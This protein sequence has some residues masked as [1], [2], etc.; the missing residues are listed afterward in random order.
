MFLCERVGILIIRQLIAGNLLQQKQVIRL[1]RVQS[2]DDIIAIT[3]RP[4]PQSVS[5]LYSFRV[6][7]TG[8]VEPISCPALTVGG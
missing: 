4:R 7:V 8:K 5:V 3:I 1:V 2:T 6:G